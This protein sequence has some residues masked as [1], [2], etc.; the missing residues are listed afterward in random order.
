MAISYEFI[1]FLS[2]KLML[3]CA[4]LHFLQKDKQKQIPSCSSLVTILNWNDKKRKFEEKFHG[5]P[6]ELYSTLVVRMVII[7]CSLQCN[8]MFFILILCP[9]FTSSFFILIRTNISYNKRPF[10]VYR[11]QLDIVQTPKE[12]E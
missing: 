5:E 8:R 12:S 11:N 7:V 6:F 3:D 10:H 9:I 4:A 2:V 1:T